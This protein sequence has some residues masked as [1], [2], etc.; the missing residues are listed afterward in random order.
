MKTLLALSVLVVGLAAAGYSQQIN[1]RALNVDQCNIVQVNLGYDF[2]MAAQIGFSRTL[3]FPKPLLVGI[4]YS[5]PMGSDLTDDFKVRLG[6]Q[7]EVVNIGGFSA[8]VKVSSLFRRYH[9]DLVRIL[10]FGSD[11]AAVVGYYHPAW[12]VAGE[13]GFDK[14]ITSHIKHSELMRAFFPGARDGWYV[15]T[16]GHYYYGLQAGTTIGES[17]DISLRAGATKAQMHDENAILPFYAQLGAGMR[18]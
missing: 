12:Y 3:A 7:M 14:A 8:A 5:F 10:N 1:W 11:F 17:F 15:S 18:F 6:A 16:G 13:F 2:G 4:E 9:T